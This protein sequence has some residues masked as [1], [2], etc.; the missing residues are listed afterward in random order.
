[1]FLKYYQMMV[2][3]LKENAILIALLM[4]I[5]ES[6]KVWAKA[7]AWYEKWMSTV[8]A[9]VVSFVLAIPE[10][11][12]V[13]MDVYTYV[14]HGVGLG[15]VAVGLYKVGSGLAKKAKPEEAEDM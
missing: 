7:Q 6:V 13:G 11:G 10:G 15:L 12:F 9:F 14:V 8:F 3:F 2:E 5:V 1:M 4:S